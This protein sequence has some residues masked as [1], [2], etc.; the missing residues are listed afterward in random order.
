MCASDGRLTFDSM[1]LEVAALTAALSLVLN[2]RSEDQSQWAT[3]LVGHLASGLTDAEFERAKAAAAEQFDALP[4]RV[5]TVA[6]LREWL[7][8]FP[9]DAV[10]QTLD[11][12]DVIVVRNDQTGE[13]FGALSGL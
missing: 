5:V 7:V 1:S 10:A 12:G 2:A 9:E 11:D 8:Q 13:S 3:R 4:E 6:E